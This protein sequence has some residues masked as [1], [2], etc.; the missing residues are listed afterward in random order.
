MQRPIY[1]LPDTEGVGSHLA[2]LETLYKLINGVHRPI[3]MS[4]FHSNHYNGYSEIRMCDYFV[5][6]SFIDCANETKESIVQ[7]NNCLLWGIE[8][9]YATNRSDYGLTDTVKLTHPIDFKKV[10][11]FA[12]K[13]SSFMTG[14]ITQMPYFYDIFH[15][16]DFTPIFKQYYSKALSILN[17]TD[18]YIDDMKGKWFYTHGSNKYDDSHHNILNHTYKYSVIHWRRKDYLDIRCN[19]NNI[20]IPYH[21][22]NVSKFIDFIYT[23]IRVEFI[24]PDSRIYIATNE[25]NEMILSQLSTYG[26]DTILNLHPFYSFPKESINYFIIEMMLMCHAHTFITSGD[27]TLKYLIRQ[28]RKKYGMWRSYVVS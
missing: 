20:T 15:D 17:Y 5:L 11:C 26:F 9:D 3:L 18:N 1:Y 2:Q 6:P 23:H 14:F 12:G 24:Q 25:N 7:N 13:I 10:D 28:C 4:T 19:R 27:T 21:C 22:F 16:I 8:E